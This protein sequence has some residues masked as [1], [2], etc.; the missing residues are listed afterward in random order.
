MNFYYGL[1]DEA[2]NAWGFV[3]ETDPRVH[4]GMVYLTTEEWQALLAGQSRGL[5]ICYYEGKV[6]NAEPG[7][8]YL[9]DDGWHK[10]TDEEFNNEKAAEKKQYLVNKIYEIKAAKAYG[11]IIINDLLIFETNQT[12]ITNTVASLSLMPDGGS[13][14]WKFYTIDGKPYV[15]QITKVQLGQLAIFGQQMINE[16]FAIEGTADAQLDQATVEQLIDAE[17]VEAFEA[18]VQTAMD[19]VNN[20]I[21]VAFS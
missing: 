13:A 14:N 9:D 8:Y 19:A 10:K 15:Q 6:F 16:C 18:Q 12:S 7:R 2:T 17:W 3:E 4:E 20:H 5:Q 11:G 1:V 21:T